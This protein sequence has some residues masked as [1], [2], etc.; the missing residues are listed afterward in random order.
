MPEIFS[1]TSKKSRKRTSIL[2]TPRNEK[3]YMDGV[4]ATTNLCGAKEGVCVC[5][6][7]KKKKEMRRKKKW[8]ELLEGA[9]W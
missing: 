2:K 1:D 4:C 5:V 3:R 9:R 6:T 7:L 8:F